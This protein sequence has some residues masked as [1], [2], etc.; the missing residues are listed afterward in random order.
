MQDAS[1]YETFGILLFQWWGYLDPKDLQ[2][3]ENEAAEWLAQRPTTNSVQKDNWQGKYVVRSRSVENA[4]LEFMIF[5]N[6][7]S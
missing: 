6:F 7:C 3:H 1:T 4:T 5:V 2:P